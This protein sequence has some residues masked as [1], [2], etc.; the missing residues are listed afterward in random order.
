M[1]LVHVVTE[2]LY[3]PLVVAAEVPYL[4]GAPDEI[5][6]IYSMNVSCVMSH[7]IHVSYYLVHCD[8]YYA[9]FIHCVSYHVSR[10]IS[11]ACFGLR[12]PVLSHQM[13]LV[14]FIACM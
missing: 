11:H 7:I 14:I 3:G 10:I 5:G 4:H 1:H 8:S 6:D 12:K 2:A 9:C 13:R